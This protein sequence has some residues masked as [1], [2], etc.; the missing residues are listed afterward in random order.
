MIWVL[1]TK[2]YLIGREIHLLKILWERGIKPFG[3]LMA[4]S[5]PGGWWIEL[6]GSRQLFLLKHV[7]LLWER[8]YSFESLSLKCHTT[9][10]MKRQ[11]KI[12]PVTP[13]ELSKA[14]WYMTYCY[15][16]FL[17]WYHFGPAQ[18]IHL[19][20]LL[21]SRLSEMIHSVPLKCPCWEVVVVGLIKVTSI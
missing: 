5:S 15:F 13:T 18:S 16:C 20:W 19:N 14:I 4:E 21:V 10:S 12:S 17:G 2:K 3:E 7:L 11:H 6:A 8:D 1:G 9:P